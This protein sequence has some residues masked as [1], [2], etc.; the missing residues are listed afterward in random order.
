M[1]GTVLALRPPCGGP[2]WPGGGACS[3]DHRM[4]WTRGR[5]V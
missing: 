4:P 5:T 3:V 1:E 2:W